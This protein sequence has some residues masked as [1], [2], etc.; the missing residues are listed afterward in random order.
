M[1]R[2]EHKKIRRLR[3]RRGTRKRILGA[4]DRP[5]LT[6]FRSARHMYAQI[7]DDLRGVT[8]CSAS[9]MEKDDKAN[10]GG[11][12]GAAAD[13]GEA[14]ASQSG[15]GDIEAARKEND[16]HRRLAKAQ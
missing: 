1:K 10:N 3:R 15:G 6:V 16:K 12:S 8:L 7:V 4:P 2:I 11:N 14:E 9:T 5:R 13:V